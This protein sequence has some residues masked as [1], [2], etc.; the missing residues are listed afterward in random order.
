MKD[1]DTP[2]E[3]AANVVDF[4]AVEKE[5]EAELNGSEAIFS[6]DTKD[7]DPESNEEEIPEPEIDD[8]PDLARDEEPAEEEVETEEE[9]E[10]EPEEDEI[11]V[12]DDPEAWINSFFK[13]KKAPAVRK[14]AAQKAAEAQAYQAQL[15]EAQDTLKAK[16]RELDEALERAETKAADVPD[17]DPLEY[18][19]L[20]E[21]ENTYVK[22][23]NRVS[24]RLSKSQREVLGGSHE[25]LR[26]RLQVIKDMEGEDAEEA[27]ADFENQIG[28]Q[29]GTRNQDR[30]MDFLEEA[31]VLNREFTDKK[32]EFEANKGEAAAAYWSE[33]W[34]KSDAQLRKTIPS[35]FDVDDEFKASNP[36]SIRTLLHNYKGQDPDRFEKM[37]NKDTETISRIINGSK[38]FNFKDAR[39]RGMDEVSAKKAYNSEVQQTKEMQASLAPDLMA[40]GLMA[41]RFI[42]VLQKQ[43]AEGGARKPKSPK[44]KTGTR[45]EVKVEKEYESPDELEKEL[46]K[47]VAETS[48]SFR[49]ALG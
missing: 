26:N 44:P 14:Y 3:V 35:L 24:N 32:Q 34:E 22:E 6:E 21:I 23:F 13:G 19:P 5:L 1:E 49:S 2:E 20:K 33:S 17:M 37:V 8:V 40:L 25:K 4:D 43:L 42:P 36:F 15:E 27:L 39:W 38:P 29:F 10:P 45:K 12:L 41:S 28:E 47:A 31:V 16:E 9:E 7:D 30:V 48:G 18:G 46:E 11:S